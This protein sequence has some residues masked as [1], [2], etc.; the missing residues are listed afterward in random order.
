VEESDEN[1]KIIEAGE[2][3]PQEAERKFKRNIDAVE[4]LEA[5]P[6]PQL[7]PKPLPKRALQARS[8]PKEEPTPSPSRALQIRSPPTE[9]P[10]AKPK[11]GLA[12]RHA[13]PPLAVEKEEALPEWLARSDSS[14]A[15]AGKKVEPGAD[16]ASKPEWFARSDDEKVEPGADDASKP[17]WFA[18]SDDEK[19]E[20][21]PAPRDPSKPE[22]F[23]GSDSS[24]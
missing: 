4:D 5:A 6:S 8:V 19:V 3:K 15:E 18:R 1:K 16:H 17:D 14:D 13:G 2:G 23:A 20:K 9:K 21:G 24:D 10:K 11:R 12:V 22:W 7:Q